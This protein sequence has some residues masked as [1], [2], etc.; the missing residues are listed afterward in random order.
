MEHV[1]ALCYL[2]GYSFMPRLRDL[3]DQHLYKMDRQADHGCLNPL[4]HGV[5]DTH[6]SANT[7]TPWCVWRLRSGNK[8]HP[9]LMAE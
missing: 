9:V 8:T 1:F 7:G 6:F 2:L 5:A 4:F 3:A